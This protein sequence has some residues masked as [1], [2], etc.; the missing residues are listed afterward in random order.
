MGIDDKVLLT[1][2][3]LRTA[4]SGR[5]YLSGLL[6]FARIVGFRGDNDREGNPTWKI[7]AGPREV[8][9]RRAHDGTGRM[10]LTEGRSSR[11]EYERAMATQAPIE[12]EF[13]D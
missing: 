6:G 10:Q 5:E 12:P 9:G 1:E 4:K 11:R 8:R 2:L 3:T 13:R 7:I